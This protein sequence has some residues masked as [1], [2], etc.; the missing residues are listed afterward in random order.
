MESEVTAM[1]TQ[2]AQTLPAA[3]IAE[4]IPDSGR[5]TLIIRAKNG[6][7]VR[8]GSRIVDVYA[9]HV[10]KTVICGGVRER[11]TTIFSSPKTTGR[12]M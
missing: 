8:S 5:V 3:T 1:K 11:H 6:M 12:L 2:I 9:D 10:I 4:V 7:P